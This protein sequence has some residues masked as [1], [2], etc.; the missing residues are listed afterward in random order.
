[1]TFPPPR[2]AAQNSI[3]SGPN[4]PSGVRQLRSQQS[5][6]GL[7]APNTDA[8]RGLTPLSTDIGSPSPEPSQRPVTSNASTSP[9]TSTFSSVLTSSNRSTSNR[10]VFSPSPSSSFPSLQSGSQQQPSNTPLLSPRSRAITPSSTFNLPSS[11]AAS[12]TASQGGGGSSGGGGGSRSQTFSPSLPLSSPT[13]NTFERPTLSSTGNSLSTAVGQSSVSKI[14]VTQVFILL[15]SI[16]EKEGK[17]KWE[18]QAEAIRKLV[19]SHGMEV[20]S[21]YFR[22]LLVGN[23]PQIFPGINRNVENPGNYQL[24]V[25][26][27][28]KVTQDPMQ[29][30]RIAEII[31][32]SE[33]DIFR[34]FDLATFLD[35]FKLDPLSK[36]LLASAFIHV[37]RTDLNAKAGAV[38]SDNFPFLLQSL[39]N[40][41]NDD[42]DASPSLLATCAFKFLQDLPETYRKEADKSRIHHALSLRFQKQESAVPIS[43]RSAMALV[44]VMETDCE[45][46]SEIHSL[47]SRST[48]SLETAKELLSKYPDDRLNENQVAVAL[49]YMTL[50]PDWQHYSLLYFISA[51]RD[52]VERPIHWPAVIRGL[53][54]RGVVIA[55]DQFL[56]IYNSLLPLAQHD[57]EFDIQMLWSGEWQNP[58]VQLSFAVAFA[59]LDP[60]DLDASSIPGLRQAYDPSECLDGPAETLRYIEEAQRD[61]SISVDAAAV[62]FN[63]TYNGDDRVS[64]EE[65]Q[66]ANDLIGGPKMGFFLCSALGVPKPWSINQDAVM[67]RLL[68]NFLLKQQPTYPYVLHSLW[69]Q[70]KNWLASKLY[71]AHT[72]NP[73][74]LP[75]LMEHAEIHGWID[76]LLSIANGF[77]LDLAA[78]AHRRNLL[79]FDQWAQDKLSKSQNTFTS[80]LVKFLLIK[81]QDEVRCARYGQD[82]PQTVSLAIKT[83][84]AMLE[85]L[86]QHA[87]DRGE[88]LVMLERQCISAFPRIIIYS[89]DPDLASENEE[90]ESHAFSQGTDADM[91]E[92]YKRMY[93]SELQV[94]DIIETLQEYKSSNDREKR[95]LFACMVH[96]LFDEYGCFRDYPLPPL[97]TTAVLFGGIISYGLITGIPLRV[98]LGMILE[99]V[100]DFSPDDNMYKF[101]LQALLHMKTN[102]EEWPGYCALLAP[103]PGLQGTEAHSKALE[104]LGRH[105]N[106]PGLGAEPNGVNGLPDGLGLSNGDI[107]DYLTP[108]IHF[109]SVHA[110]PPDSSGFY[111]DPDEEAQEKVVFFFNNVSEQNLTAKLQELQKSLDERHRQWFASL[112]V[113]ERAKLEPNLQQLYL[114]MLKLLGDKTLWNEVLRET[115]SSIQK[116]LNAESTMSSATERKNLKSLATWLGSLTIARDRPI[117]HKNISFKDLLIE[118]CDTERLLIV[119]PFTCNV[120]IQAKSSMVFKPPNPWTVE[121]IRFLLELYK[122]AELKLNQKFE[123]EVLC[124]ELDVDRNTLEPSSVFRNKSL[125]NEELSG[126]LLPEGVD[127]FEDLTLGSINRNGRNARFSPSSIAS[128]LP[129]LQNLLAFP[130]SSGSAATQARLREIVREA[131]QRAILEIIAPVVER[132]VTIATIATTS[133]IHKDFAREENEDRIRRAAQQMV[134]QLSGSLAL[135]TCKEPLRMSMTNFIRKAQ[136]DLP[137]QDI[138]EGA[139]LM[140]VN[141][142]LDLACGIVEKQAEERSMPE[143]EAHIENEIAARRQHRAEHANEQYLDPSY[144]RWASYIPDPYKLSAGGLN[145]EQLNIYYDFARQSRGPTS[146]AQTPSADSGRQLPDVL[147]EAFAPVSNLPTP[148]EAPAIPHQ[149]PQQH[150]NPRMLPPPV[151]NTMSQPQTNGYYDTRLVQER[152]QD[153]IAEIGRLAQGRPEKALKELDQKGPMVSVINQIWDL[154]ISSSSH[155]D[156]IAWTTANIACMALYGDTASLL[157]IDVLVQLLEKL[158]QLSPSTYKEIVVGFANQDDEKYFNAPVTTALL[159]TGLLEIRQVD[160]TLTKL[161]QDRREPALDA[162]SEIVDTLLLGDHPVILRADLAES[163]GEVGYWLASSPRNVAARDLVQKLK[164]WG[165]PETISFN[166]DERDRIKQHQLQ[167]TFSEWLALCSQSSPTAKMLGSFISQLHQRQILNSQE[168]MTLFLRICIDS[169]I[170][171]HERIEGPETTDGFFSIDGIAKLLVL[172]V[173][174]QGQSDGAVQGSKSAYMHT[175]LSLVTLV[176][177]HHHVMRGEQ[178]NQ[179]AFFRLFSSVLNEWNDLARQ[180]SHQDRE[181]VLVFADIFMRLQPRQFPS[182]TYSWLTLVSHRMFMP[183]ILKLQ[184]D[185]GWEPFAKIMDAIFSYMSELVN[186][187]MTSPIAKELYRGA[188][189]ILLILHHDFPEFLAEN[190]FRLCNTIPAHC[191]QLRNLVLSAFPSSFADVPDPFTAGLKVDRLEE[192]RRA[193]R[194]AGDNLSVFVHSHIKDVVDNALMTND[195]SEESFKLIFDACKPFSNNSTEDNRKLL[196]A[197]VLYIGESAISS[198]D[199]RSGPAFSND[200]PQAAL[201]SKLARELHPDARYHFLSSIANQ[202]RYPN[203]HTHYFS[204]A[205][206]HLFGNDLVDQQESDV[207]QQITRVLLER[208]I[209]HRPHPWGLIITLLE[210]LKNPAYMFWDLPFIKAAPEKPPFL[211]NLYFLSPTE[212]MARTNRGRNPRTERNRP[213]AGRHNPITR[214]VTT[215]SIILDSYLFSSDLLHSTRPSRPQFSGRNTGAGRQASNTASSGS[216]DDQPPVSISSRYSSTHTSST[217]TPSIDPHE[218]GPMSNGDY[219]Q[220]TILKFPKTYLREP[221]DVYN[222]RLPKKMTAAVEDVQGQVEARLGHIHRLNVQRIDALEAELAKY[223]HLWAIVLQAQCHGA[224][225]QEIFES[226]WRKGSNWTPSDMEIEEME[227]QRCY[228]LYDAYAGWRDDFAAEQQLLREFEDA[229][230]D[231]PD[232]SDEDWL[233]KMHG[234]V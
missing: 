96:G 31:D 18:S 227:E 192:V 114:D 196:H 10:A 97:A 226:E 163:I 206:L 113:E 207:R 126:G 68:M 112:L 69:K 41:H 194:A 197:L 201:M 51:I 106:Q 158:C 57:P 28:K 111:E 118:A 133:L 154:I 110:D 62:L 39:A 105:E 75:L 120:L 25:Q 60:S 22:R 234:L 193:P 64:Q 95:D 178:F 11:A 85:V 132:S 223:K 9:F 73:L 203:S 33:V 32:A 214:P 171:A 159:E 228:V 2:P 6:W 212:E 92:L 21:K 1:M 101:G 230:G 151:P 153:L 66:A 148:A 103:I 77:G 165:V 147:Q 63:L 172:L 86:Q 67:S 124:K 83:V 45:L 170:D 140:C 90:T 26:E 119:I 200:S 169:A 156:M 56:K 37:S 81:V 93:N 188:L 136:K 89:D 166:P 102:L 38:L 72:K 48:S 143:I 150:Q 177:N 161:L 84:V 141:D 71:Q 217:A 137:E 82:H 145:S 180:G 5:A 233:I 144:S 149:L 94:R 91:Q 211:P 168:D 121:I 52:Y 87:S 122:F 199:Q 107:D 167:Y 182:F 61:P 229:V 155:I 59:S 79:D 44:D 160:L 231:I 7:P 175:L 220:P 125:Q 181:I 70:D 109:K 152:I 74:Q 210:L 176:L 29:A 225:H 27:M 65:E 116:M 208:L 130:P 135:V 219:I 157:E 49:L 123:I 20:F 36:T 15:G 24:L 202:L 183:P 46:A 14:V 222:I 117:K 139:I 218:V 34:D 53:D 80:A 232:D 191:T 40:A 187:A 129:D 195:I 162:L 115:Y 19:D 209:V 98:G 17:A 4:K 164:H 128:S 35:H 58:S 13:S 76:D 179:R 55:P 189:R 224:E 88:D 23:S 78:L 205:L 186:P 108:S 8:R 99:A 185:D 50:C 104:V 146:H 184:D 131:V 42:F 174:T 127:G 216:R 100:R 138:A 16:T 43:I 3:A 213:G 190:H 142:N 47:G 173:K 221:H 204:Y 12:T 30:S 134:R 215:S 54:R 198:L